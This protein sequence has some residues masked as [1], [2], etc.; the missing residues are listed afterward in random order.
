MTC[1]IAFCSQPAT[2][3]VYQ[4]PGDHDSFLPL[5]GVSA[6]DYCEAHAADVAAAFSAYLIETR[7]Q[8]LDDIVTLTK[9]GA[10]AAAL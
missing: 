4:E 5:G 3:T 8:M 6:P 7:E 9:A 10:E 2:H 1:R